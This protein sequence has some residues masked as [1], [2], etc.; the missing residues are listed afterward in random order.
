[1]PQGCAFNPRCPDATEECRIKKPEMVE[2]EEGHFVA[3]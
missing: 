3:C 1:V 2:V